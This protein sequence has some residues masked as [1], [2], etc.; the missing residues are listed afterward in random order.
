MSFFKDVE[1]AVSNAE[2]SFWQKHK[3][4]ILGYTATAITSAIISHIVGKLL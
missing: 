4:H 2:K 1:N 3:G